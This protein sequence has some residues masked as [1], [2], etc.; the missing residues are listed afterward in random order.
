MTTKDLIAY[1]IASSWLASL[2]WLWTQELA[3]YLITRK[4]VRKYRRWERLN[5]LIR[6]RLDALA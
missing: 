6:G 1:E 3:V 2:P 5:A 4:V